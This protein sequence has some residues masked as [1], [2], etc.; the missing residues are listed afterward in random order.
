M[1]HT[2]FD[3]DVS[4]WIGPYPFR[5][6]PHPD[7][8]VLVHVLQRERIRQAWVGS[9]PSAWHRDPAPSNQWLYAQLEPHRDVLLPSPTVRPDWPG[10]QGVLDEAV[11]R[12]ATSVRTYPMQ[13]GIGGTSPLLP[14]LARACADR[15]LVLQFTVR[16]E[17]LRQRHPMDAVPDLTA[18]HVRAAVRADPRVQVIV[19]G[20]GRELI[21][22][23]H[24]SLTPGEQTR[25]FWDWAWVWGPPE[26][27]LAHLLATMGADRFVFGGYWPMRLIQAPLATLSLQSALLPAVTISSAVE[28]ARNAKFLAGEGN[29]VDP[30]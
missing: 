8:A 7:A 18:A 19:S 5:E 28:I 23:V 15:G 6:L 25:C 12:G 30:Q 13:L 9:L 27:H 1:T 14:Q 29:A 22:E 4:A 11:T 10:W 16:F 20:A 21:E 3:V 26:D 2:R 17:D 24:W